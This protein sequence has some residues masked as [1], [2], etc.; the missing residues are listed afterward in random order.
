LKTLIAV[1]LL[2]I[3]IFLLAAVSPVPVHAISASFPDFAFSSA[4]ISGDSLN[5]TFTGIPNQMTASTPTAAGKIVKSN[6]FVKVFDANNKQLSRVL[7]QEGGTPGNNDLFEEKLA[8]NVPLAALK[9]TSSGKYLL[10]A[11]A[12]TSN[13]E[14]MASSSTTVVYEIPNVYPPYELQLSNTGVLVTIGKID[15][16]NTYFIVVK[17]GDTVIKRVQAKQGDD[18][19]TDLKP[20]TYQIVLEIAAG[21]Y[22]EPRTIVV[23]EQQQEVKPAVPEVI[24]SVPTVLANGTITFSLPAGSQYASWTLYIEVLNNSDTVLY[25]QLI[26]DKTKTLRNAQLGQGNYK[27]RIKAVQPSSEVIV[28]SLPVVWTVPAEPV[29]P[30]KRPAVPDDVKVP[31]TVTVNEGGTITVQID[32]SGNYSKF[33]YILLVNDLNG[34][35]LKTVTLYSA[36]GIYSLKRLNLPEGN[37]VL[38]IKMVNNQTNTFTLSESFPW[39]TVKQNGVIVSGSLPGAIAPS[40]GGRLRI[41]IQPGIYYS[42]YRFYVVVLN[43]KGQEAQRM[44][45]E[46]TN[47]DVSLEQLKLTEG[48][49]KVKIIM[50]NPLTGTIFSSATIPWIIV[51]GGN[52]ANPFPGSYVIGQDG[53]ITVKIRTDGAFAKFK[54]TLIILDRN[55]SPLREIPITVDNTVVNPSDLKLPDGAYAVCL[56]MTDPVTDQSVHSEEETL[57]VNTTGSTAIFIDGQAQNYDSLPIIIDGS[58]LVPMRAIFESFSAKVDWDTPTQTVTA[59]KDDLRIKLTIASTIAWIQEDR[60]DLEVP[61][62]LIDSKTMVP[63]RFVS[64]ALGADVGWDARTKS[65]IIQ[66]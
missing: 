4:K 3:T 13:N 8:I 38:L 59:L 22:S 29:A 1:K 39:S 46:P 65:I 31:G 63:I 49:Y 32:R 12:V 44:P 54:Y 24:Q 15:P 47:S 35:T 55:R 33:T 7:V 58:T 45:V 11:E 10:T 52:E 34:N 36:K 20:G 64:E 66:K 57:A 53:G 48:I 16:P 14:V 40:T 26:K 62:Q 50:V 41:V 5:A 17:S 18:T 25:T 43:G 28:Y 23:P 61:A 19:L 42:S 27:V 2:F 30:D 21:I 9:I 6:V 51:N 37:Y 56:N 60:N